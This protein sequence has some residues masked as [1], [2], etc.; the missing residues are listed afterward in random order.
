MYNATQYAEVAGQDTMPTT[1]SS[2][3]PAAFQMPLFMRLREHHCLPG[4]ITIGWGEN[5]Y[6]REAEGLSNAFFPPETEFN[7][8]GVRLFVLYCFRVH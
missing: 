3:F 1:L 2:T 6:S 7:E 8:H 5:A 4:Q